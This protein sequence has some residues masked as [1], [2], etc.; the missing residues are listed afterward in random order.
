MLSTFFYFEQANIVGAAIENR[1]QRV[2][3]LARMD[4][5]V[6]VLTILIQVFFTAQSD[7]QT[8]P[9]LRRRQLCPSTAMLGFIALAISPTLWVIVAIVVIERAVTFSLASPAAKVLYTTLE[10]D[11]KFKAQNFIDTVVY[12]GGDA[13]SGVYFDA[14]QKSLGFALTG[15]TLVSLPLA[16]VWL[17]LSFVLERMF[18]ER[19][20][21]QAVTTL[22][23]YHH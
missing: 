12:R 20:N 13:L 5:A 8:G 17:G 18:R 7:A 3:F 1:D 21:A 22:T 23:P 10:P 2:Q 16:G 11:E 15:V 19:E 4:F 9:R 14:L 6:S